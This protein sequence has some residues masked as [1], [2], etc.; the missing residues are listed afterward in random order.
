MESMKKVI[1]LIILLLV[2]QLATLSFSSALV[3]G[4]AATARELMRLLSALATWQH[5]CLT[6]F[7]GAGGL[8]LAVA[9]ALLTGIPCG[10]SK[11]AMGLV[12]PLVVALQGCPPVIW[13]S[14]L[15]VWVG[16]GTVV[17]VV[18]VFASVFPMLFLNVAQGVA[19]LDRRLLTM[20][21]VYRFSKWRILR[22][23]I[24]PGISSYAL[25]AFS[26][27][28]GVSWKVTATAEFFG[29]GSGI[30]SQLYWSYRILDMPR[31]FGW[32]VILILIGLALE[33]SLI[34]PL[35][36]VVATRR[37]ASHD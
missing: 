6:L 34:H 2:W 33:M 25:A 23:I 13:I 20:A 32:A 21:R 22:H 8:S 37:E 9:L 19:A 7:R 26:F 12:A 17:P 10:F 5:L 3:P 29:S 35:R 30:G 18:V 16:T 28:L 1:P 36:H 15:L 4:P 11:N 14:L 31:L 27:A 24:L